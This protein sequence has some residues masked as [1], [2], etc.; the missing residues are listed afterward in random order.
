MQS[1][2][3]T[4]VPWDKDEEELALAFNRGFTRG[5]LKGALHREIMGRSHPDHRGIMVGTVTSYNPQIH[6][7]R[8]R[9]SGRLF[10]T[11]AMASCLLIPRQR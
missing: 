6:L 1:P 7:A 10:L 5:Y 11:K 4:G 9:L 8:I 2:P 3:G